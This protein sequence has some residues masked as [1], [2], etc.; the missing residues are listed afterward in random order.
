MDGEGGWSSTSTTSTRPTSGTFTW[1]LRRFV[2][3]LALMCW[4]KALPDE[5]S[6]SWSP[7]Y[8]RAYVDQVRHFVESDRDH[9]G[10]C[11]STP[12]TAP[13]SPRC[14]RPGCP[15]GSTCSTA[16][17]WSRT[18]SA[19][20][21]G[22]APCASWGRR[23][24]KQVEKA[25]AGY[26][27]TI[28][29]SKRQQRSLTY[30]MKD[31]VGKLGVRHRQ[32]RAAGVQPAGRGPRPGAGERRRASMKQGN[33]A[34][35]E[36]GRRRRGGPVVLPHQGHRTAVSQSAL[37]AHTDPWLGWTEVD[38]I[39][40]VVAELSPYEADLDWS[41]P[42]RARG[43]PAGGRA[44]GRATAKVHCVSDEDSRTG[45]GRLPD[46]GRGGRGGRRTGW[47]SWWPT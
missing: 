45:P 29:E 39:G 46:R 25:Y 14:C 42:V 5:R 27:D 17:P 21:A 31:V 12:P 20:S 24:R 22:A 28:P 38:G 16:S 33:V 18:T 47:T 44:L 40:Y 3:S 15:P 19:G 2:A 23:E 26:L 32:R 35:A 6:T 8:L 41:D 13:C 30:A 11:G 34:G 4:Q 1:D 9:G 7:R 10:R 36:P 37:Q 43:H